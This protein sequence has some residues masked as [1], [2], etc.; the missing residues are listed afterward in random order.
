[1]KPYEAQK[2]VETTNEVFGWERL[3][4]DF[5]EKGKVDS[6]PFN[7]EWVHLAEVGDR[8]LSVVVAW[9][10]VKYNQYF[11]AKRGYLGPAATIP[12]YRSKKLASALT[13][14][15]MNFLYEKGLDTVILHTS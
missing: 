10:A 3:K 2:V 11:G 8:I 9:P 4:L 14:R 1:M 5:V 6:P 15:A 13:V 7:E 12:G